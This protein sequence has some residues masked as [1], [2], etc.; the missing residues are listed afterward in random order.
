MDQK[1]KAWIVVFSGLGV[2]LTL[3]VL[4]SWGVIS[5]A[6]IDQLE[7]TATQTQ[8]PYMVASAIF[9]FTMIPAGRM[10]DRLG[11]RIVL[12]LAS[13]LA[14]A[15]FVLSG[16]QLGVIELTIFFG[17]MFG[18]AMGFGYASPTPAAVKWYHTNHRGF[19][20]GLV[21]SGFGLAPIYIAPLANTLLD[22]IGIQMTFITFGVFFFL[23]VF[24]LS[25]LIKNPPPGHVPIELQV[26]RTPPVRMARQDVDYKQ[27]LKCKQFYLIWLLFF[28]G[29]FAG[30]LIIGQMQKIG[31]E[32]AG[33][34][35]AFL[36][37]AVY[38]FFNF[39]GRISWGS[40]SDQI[41]RKQTLFVMFAIQVLVFLLFP[42]F[43]HPFTLLLGK[44]FVGFT[45]GG[46]LTIFPALSAD[47]YG[48]KHLGVNYGLMITAW[49]FG[50]VLG[51][52]FGGMARDITGG[53]NASYIA[54]MILSALGAGLSLTIKLPK[55]SKATTD[56]L[57]NPES[58]KSESVQLTTAQEQAND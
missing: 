42:L 25:F 29:T 20:T 7:W 55:G 13:I 9:A 40:I 11:P 23:I 15:G 24:T 48:V 21:V 36:I 1:K 50:G 38:A 30:L 54:A 6:L 37:V 53:Y 58:Q 57:P 44:S 32:Q 4:Y 8:I 56:R 52:L 12:L 3:G 35:N 49:G 16:L 18:L 14:G 5:A 17:I 33:M 41:G 22:R 26:K 28:F 31:Q 47:L 45:F 27:M 46:M 51:P 19:I 34:E 39:L 2:N 10:Q 43:S